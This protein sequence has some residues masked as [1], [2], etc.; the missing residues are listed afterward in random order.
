MCTFFLVGK[1]K[2]NLRFVENLGHYNPERSQKFDD[3]KKKKKK[4]REREI[5]LANLTVF[6]F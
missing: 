1:E 4:N 2:K 3:K 5:S 6:E